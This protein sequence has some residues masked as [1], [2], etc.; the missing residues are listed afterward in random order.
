MV[1]CVCALCSVASWGSRPFEGV[2][3]DQ[4]QHTCVLCCAQE[5]SPHRLCFSPCCTAPPVMHAPVLWCVVLS[6]QLLALSYA[7]YSIPAVLFELTSAA[8]HSEH[9]QA[10][11]IQW[12]P[13]LLRWVGVYLDAYGGS[14]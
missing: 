11:R 8:L 9:L 1:G 2:S 3:T 12:L 6:G 13:E 14:T 4:Q 5:P 7:A 10:C